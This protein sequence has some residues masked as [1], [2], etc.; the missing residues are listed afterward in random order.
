MQRPMRTNRGLIAEVN[1]RPDLNVK[2]E[3]KEQSIQIHPHSEQQKEHE[4]KTVY[5]DAEKVRQGDYQEAI[6]PQPQEIDHHGCQ[7]SNSTRKPSS[8]NHGSSFTQA[9]VDEIPKRIADVWEHIDNGLDKWLKINRTRPWSMKKGWKVVK[10]FVSSTFTDFYSE[11]E[12]LI[13][14]VV[15]QLN[16]WCLERKIQLI[17]CDLRWGIPKDSTANDTI[18]ICLN[19]IE[20]C[21]QETGGQAFFLN[22]LG[23][24]YGWIPNLDEISQEVVNKYDLING[25]SITHTEIL[26]ASLRSKSKNALFLFRNANVILQLPVELQLLFLESTEYGQQSLAELKRQLRDRFPKQVLDYSCSF[27]SYE[28]SPESTKVTL[29]DLDEFGKKVIDYFKVAIERT[30]PQIDEDLAQ[31]EWNFVFQDI[32]IE[33]KGALLV[34]REAERS[35]KRLLILCQVVVIIMVT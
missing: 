24:R 13:K 33:K 23:E 30:Y 26:Q 25:I 29:T 4:E 8:K 31:D 28:M 34:G 32:F 19:E 1:L 22:L 35:G 16:E 2:S 18:N 9:I 14:R 12:M 7:E 21:L 20:Q 17:E 10:L 6:I 5:E 27:D 11:R 15:P 3:S